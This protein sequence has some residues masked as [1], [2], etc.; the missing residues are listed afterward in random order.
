[1]K[2]VELDKKTGKIV[3]KKPLFMEMQGT[4][5]VFAVLATIGGAVFIYFLMKYQVLPIMRDLLQ[6]AG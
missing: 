4:E 6:S 1:M 2:R 3:N 5:T